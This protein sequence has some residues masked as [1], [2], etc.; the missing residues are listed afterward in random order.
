MKIPATLDRLRRV[1]Q[2]S[3]YSVTCT[4]S[5][6]PYR[7]LRPHPPTRTVATPYVRRSGAHCDVVQSGA[8]FVS[9]C[10]Y[11]QQNSGSLT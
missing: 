2:L 3:H 11:S 6:S 4:E 9:Y 1:G 10:K 8:V 7:P 5:P